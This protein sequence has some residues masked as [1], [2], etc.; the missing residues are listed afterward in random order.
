MFHFL[1]LKDAQDPGLKAVDME[2]SVATLSSLADK[3][4]LALVFLR[5]STKDGDKS[6][7]VV[8]E[9]LLRK[10]SVDEDFVDVRVAVVGNVDAGKSTLLGVLTHGEL[11]NGRGTARMKLFRHKHEMESGRTSSVGN[12]ILGFSSNGTVVITFIDLAGHER[13]LKTTVFGMT[14][15]AP[16]FAML[17]VGG[18]AGI[19]GMTKEHLGLALALQVPVF[20]V[21]TKIDMCPKNV[22]AETVTLLF[23]I[24][25]RPGCKKLPILV[26]EHDDVILAATNFTS[27]RMCPI[28][29]VSNVTGENLDLLKEFL[30][31]LTPRANPQFEKPAE[32]QID[33]IFSVQGVGIVVSGTCICG[34]IA[35]NNNMYLG[36]DPTGAFATV[37]IKSIQRKRLPV[38]KVCGGQTASFAL[39]RVKRSQ[40]RKGMVLISTALEPYSCMEFKAEVLI[41]HHPT[42]ISV[43]YQAMIHTGPIRQTATIVNIATEKQLRTGMKDE[44]TFRFIKQPEYIKKEQRLVFREGKTKAVGT[45]IDVTPYVPKIGVLPKM[46][47]GQRKQFRKEQFA[48][49]ASST[50]DAP[51][52]SNN[53]AQTQAPVLITE[54]AKLGQTSNRRR[55]QGGQASKPE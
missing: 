47:Q 10:L 15:H 5:D 26:Q 35:L 14:G 29:A 9:Y 32:F 2:A 18:N 8:K 48:A 54:I 49:S 28:F 55:K 53:Q 33:E 22:L 45:I 7:L 3:M 4:N 50:N 17:M 52:N 37:P 36:P 31:L 25:K 51:C 38:S 24:L 16:D 39:K 30:N 41:L 42:T 6:G 40:L 13:Y 21:I 11:D 19:I 44:V 20:V 12:D 27:E 46:R 1:N 23:K 34:T 43:G